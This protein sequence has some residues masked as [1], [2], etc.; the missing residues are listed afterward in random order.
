MREGQQGGSNRKSRSGSHKMQENLPHFMKRYVLHTQ[1]DTFK[2][3]LQGKT[4]ADKMSKLIAEKDA[5]IAE[6][7][8]NVS[9]AQVSLLLLNVYGHKPHYNQRLQQKATALIT[10]CHKR[11]L[12]PTYHNGNPRPSGHRECPLWTPCTS[13]SGI[14][15][16]I[17][18]CVPNRKVW[19][20]TPCKRSREPCYRRRAQF[21]YKLMYI[22]VY[23]LR[24]QIKCPHEYFV[25]AP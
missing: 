8:K 6:E 19:R 2:H 10:N 1:N 9:Y 13:A 5:A 16:T 7:N 17:P 15:I 11:A 20:R 22:A 14:V 18:L 24:I 25:C 4:L 23:I 21:I 12:H 3:I